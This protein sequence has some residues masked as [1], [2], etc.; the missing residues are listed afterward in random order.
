[1]EKLRGWFHEAAEAVELIMAV[2][3]FAAIV[4]ATIGLVPQFSHFWHERADSEALMELLRAI[5]S[6]V[7][8]SEFISMLCRPSLENVTEVLI[9]LIARHM[10]VLEMSALESLL[11]VI[12]IAILFLLQRYIRITKNDPSIFRPF[13]G[14]KKETPPED[15]R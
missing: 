4:I 8:A 2:F 9:F 11:L 1:M 15:E 14:K 10:I 3:V 12:S 5:L 7:I 6:I 13:K